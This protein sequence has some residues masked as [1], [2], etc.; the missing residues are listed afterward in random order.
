MSK[1]STHHHATKPKASLY[2]EITAHI[3]ADL[4]AGIFPWAR[5][6]GTG[7]GSQ[8]FALHSK[9][10]NTIVTLRRSGLPLKDPRSRKS[11]RGVR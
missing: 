6:W 11:S 10:R 4:E 1:G 2:E 5:P 3:I 9:R 7:G 8:A